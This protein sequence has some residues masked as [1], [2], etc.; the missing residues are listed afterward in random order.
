[1]MIEVTLLS[2]CGI[3]VWYWSAYGH[4]AVPIDIP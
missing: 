2:L 3:V 1:M 4:P